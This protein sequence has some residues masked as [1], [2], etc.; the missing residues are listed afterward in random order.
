MDSQ[1][2]KKSSQQVLLN[3][4]LDAIVVKGKKESKKNRLI[5]IMF[6]IIGVVSFAL[7]QY[8]LTVKRESVYQEALTAQK[9]GEYKTAISLFQE[10]GD[11]QD[12]QFQLEETTFAYDFIMSKTFTD[13]FDRALS[14]FDEGDDTV[15]IK[16][17]I[18]NRTVILSKVIPKVNLE[19]ID[20]AALVYLAPIW[21]K[22]DIFTNDVYQKFP[23]H[24]YSS[25]SCTF[26]FKDEE[27]NLLY[28]VNN[29]KTVY[30]YMDMETVKTLAY[31]EIYSNIVGLVNEEKYQAAYDY[32][33]LNDIDNFYDLEYKDLSD[34]YYYAIAL[35]GCD[36]TQPNK[37]SQRLS[38]LEKVSSNFKDVKQLTDM[39]KP[40]DLDGVY[41]KPEEENGPS[42]VLKIHIIISGDR[43]YL[44]L[45]DANEKSYRF[46]YGAGDITW[47]IENGKPS[48]GT[49]KCQP[50][51]IKLIPHSNGMTVEWRVDWSQEFDSYKSGTYTKLP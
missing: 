51:A 4:D 9:A 17:D 27:G 29:G 26:E 6:V 35:I 5:A 20:P 48:Y 36:K 11:F 10:L 31:E 39:W 19:R 7:Y 34:Y 25:I 16:Y 38:I 1:N 15:G 49:A 18:N 50:Y 42:T 14:E 21:N 45:Y 22:A 3:V 46:M 12:C 44:Y 43:A 24:G 40:F 30:S 32:W 23:I 37:V 41:E 33:N 47:V 8:N 2:T 28:S 13:L